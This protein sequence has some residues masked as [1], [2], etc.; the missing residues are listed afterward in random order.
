M[1]ANWDSA[2]QERFDRLER[3]VETLGRKLDALDAKV[4]V[5]V[6]SLDTKVDV[7]V[8]QLREDIK[9]LGEGY[10]AG[11]QGISRQ[12]ADIDRNWDYKWSPHDLAIRDHE[13]RLKKIER[14]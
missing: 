3:N 2:M 5:R 1:A 6:S 8:E 14:K 10:E 11:F 4:D 9:K 12:I 7:L 13:A